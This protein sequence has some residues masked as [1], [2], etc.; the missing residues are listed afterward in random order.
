MKKEN[1]FSNFTERME[2]ARKKRNVRSIIY[3]VLMI[4]F[5]VIVTIM[6]QLIGNKYN[7]QFMMG[8]LCMLLIFTINSIGSLLLINLNKKEIQKIFDEEQKR[9]LEEKMKNI[10]SDEEC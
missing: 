5:V 10:K 6:F 3:A 1:N 2:K 4:L 8:Q 7:V 9:L